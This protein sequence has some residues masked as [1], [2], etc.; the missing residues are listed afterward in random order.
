M[1]DN[2]TT[3]VVSQ[4]ALNAPPWIAGLAQTVGGFIIVYVA[5]HFNATLSIADVLSWLLPLM[6]GLNGV[7]GSVVSR[8]SKIKLGNIGNVVTNH[9]IQTVQ[10]QTPTGGVQ[11]IPVVAAVKQPGT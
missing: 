2:T 1:A 7:I 11:N 5:R 3:P 4:T 10:V 8:I 6:L 9:A